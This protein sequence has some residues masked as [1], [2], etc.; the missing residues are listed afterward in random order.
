MPGH[1]KMTLDSQVAKHA[2]P[3]RIKKNLSKTHA[4]PVDVEH[5]KTKKGKTPVK[6]ALMDNIKRKRDKRN[7]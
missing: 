3:D 4:F 2:S 6:V 1:T 5:T 7:V